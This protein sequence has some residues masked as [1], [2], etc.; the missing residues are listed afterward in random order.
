MFKCEETGPFALL[1]ALLSKFLTRQA[2]RPWHP[3]QGRDTAVPG[4]PP[5]A[6]PIMPVVVHAIVDH[7]TPCP[8]ALI[9][10][11]STCAEARIVR[12]Q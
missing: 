9:M 4:M 2:P 10:C 12:T 7:S 1:E 3:S 5:I 8:L 6:V 11:F